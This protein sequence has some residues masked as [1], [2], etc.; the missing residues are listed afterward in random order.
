METKIGND[1]MIHKIDF[2]EIKHFLTA[3][4]SACTVIQIFYGNFIYC[5]VSLVYPCELSCIYNWV[6]HYF[7]I[8]LIPLQKKTSETG[9]L[10]MFIYAQWGCMCYSFLL[11]INYNFLSSFQHNKCSFIFIQNGCFSSDCL[12]KQP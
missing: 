11:S 9:C 4:V 3:A 2:G 1:P 8:L 6:P 12:S 7:E 10:S 5:G